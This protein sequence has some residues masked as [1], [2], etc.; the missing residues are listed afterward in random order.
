MYIVTL[1]GSPK[2]LSRSS[3][4]LG[5]VSERLQSENTQIQS[6]SLAQFDQQALLEGDFSH[7]TI[8]QFQDDVE[9]ADGLVI[10]TPIYKAAYSGLLKTMLDVL[11]QD[12]LA[13]KVILP[14]ASGGTVAHLLAIDYALKPILTS[15]KAQEILSGVFA[16]DSQIQVSEQG[17]QL[18]ANLRERLDL[19][20]GQFQYVLRCRRSMEASLKTAVSVSNV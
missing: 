9:R 6:Y 19:A 14:V 16:Q 3:S 12:A 13:H 7:P 18:E 1:A 20:V 10:A 15:M 5:Y 17:V 4:L 11:A 8:R 2:A